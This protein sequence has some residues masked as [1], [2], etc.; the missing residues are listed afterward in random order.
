[1]KKPVIKIIRF[2]GWLLLI[3]GFGL[4]VIILSFL[5][6]DKDMVIGTRIGVLVFVVVLGAL[7]YLGFRLARFRKKQEKENSINEPLNDERNTVNSSDGI[8]KKNAKKK[9]LQKK[10]D[11]PKNDFPEGTYRLKYRDAEGL[12]SERH[13]TI[14]KLMLGDN[15]SNSYIYAYCFSALDFRQFRFDRIRALYLDNEKIKDP[16]SYLMEKYQNLAGVDIDTNDLA[17]EA[18]EAE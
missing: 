12:S 1:M 17:N 4:D 3:L 16:Y 10:K 14:K 6:S 8:Q 2:W 9:E 18:L 11:K 5:I 15:P 13:I 7:G